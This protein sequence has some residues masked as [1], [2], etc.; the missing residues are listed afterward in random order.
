MSSNSYIAVLSLGTLLMGVS[1]L[2]VPAPVEESKSAVTY[3]KDV[4]PILQKNC[5]GCHRPG[6]IGPFSML[7]YKDTRPWAKAI[8]AAVVAKTMPP[9]LADP[10][11][12]HFENDRSLKLDEIDKI[13][14]WVDSGAPEGDS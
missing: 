3:S 7:S 12:G 4:L 6:Q 2:A 5:Q 13:A 11:Y 14:A 10:Q 1:T 8:K 9:W